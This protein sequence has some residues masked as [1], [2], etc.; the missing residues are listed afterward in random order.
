[1]KKDSLDQ[2]S[3]TAFRLL[4][5]FFF[6]STLV[7]RK[8]RKDR[9]TDTQTEMA[10]QK[11]IIKCKECDGDDLNADPVSPFIAEDWCAEKNFS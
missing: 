7:G 10:L 4:L 5:F 1:V 9:Q 2:S 6:F 11:R 8:K 3:F